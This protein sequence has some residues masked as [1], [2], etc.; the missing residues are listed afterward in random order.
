MIIKLNYQHINVHQLNQG[1]DLRKKCQEFRNLL[2]VL[3]L[4]LLLI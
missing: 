4:H 1:H 2:D 3:H